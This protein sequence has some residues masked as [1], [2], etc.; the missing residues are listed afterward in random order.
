MWCVKCNKDLSQCDCPDLKERLS[1][2][3]QCPSIHIPSMVLK[4]LVEN[5]AR[6]NRP[7]EK[8]EDN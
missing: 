4:P 5:E 3:A 8:A 2:L 1:R 6:R 7:E